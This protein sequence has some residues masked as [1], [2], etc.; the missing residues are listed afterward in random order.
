MDTTNPRETTYS[1][2]QACNLA[3]ISYRQLDYWCRVGTMDAHTPATGSGS[4]RRWTR[5]Q[6]AVLAVL[7]VVAPHARI[8]QLDELA[9]VLLDWDAASWADQVLLLNDGGVWRA[10]APGAPP[11]GVFVNLGAVIVAV[12]RRAAQLYGDGR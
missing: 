6:V 9:T 11:A 2:A 7:G 5:Q 1:S 12:E 3:G 8:S 4:R 10:A